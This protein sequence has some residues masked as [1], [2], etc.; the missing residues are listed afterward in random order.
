[1][2]VYAQDRETLWIARGLQAIQK[3]ERINSD[4]KKKTSKGNEYKL[5]I[6]QAYA[7]IAK[8]PKEFIVKE[9][10]GA[11]YKLKYDFGGSGIYGM[12]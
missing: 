11:R 4:Q 8:N 1:M 12:G 2:N 5:L 9:F 7:N 3:I 10:T 6:E